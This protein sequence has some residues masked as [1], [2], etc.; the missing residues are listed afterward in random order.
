LNKLREKISSLLGRVRSRR[1]V[2]HAITNWV[3]GGDVANALQALGAR[4]VLAFSTTEV[5]EIT[6]QADALLLNLGTPTPE[7]IAA[8][9]L[10]GRRANELD[11]PVV[12]DPVGAGASAFRGE[13][14]RRILSEVKLTV[15]RGNR[16]E[17]GA[18]AGRGGQL[19]GIDAVSGPEDLPEAVRMLFGQTGAVVVVSGEQDLL[20][21]G[22][23]FIT[24]GSGHPLMARITGAGCMLGAAIAAFAA[25]GKDFPTAAVAAV[26]CF[27]RAGEL[28]GRE[29]AGP[30]TFRARLLDFLFNLTPDDLESVLISED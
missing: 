17:I 6:A 27:K 15:V 7:R 8:M 12:F 14:C 16:A 29:A 20:F 26:V 4:P 19:R 11:R 1:P 25:V 22:Q 30:G 5:A 10:A 18:L 23:G 28:A 9:V 21:G 3:T 2:V 13:A 24:V